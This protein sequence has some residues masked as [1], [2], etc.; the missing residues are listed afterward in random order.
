MYTKIIK[1]ETLKE[2]DELDCLDAFACSTPINTS[3]TSLTDLVI[4]VEIICCMKKLLESVYIPRVISILG[5]PN[6]WKPQLWIN[7]KK[8]KTVLT[9]HVYISKRIRMYLG[10]SGWSS[11]W[12]TQQKQFQGILF[13][14]KSETITDVYIMDYCDCDSLCEL[15]MRWKQRSDQSEEEGNKIS[16]SETLKQKGRSLMLK[17]KGSLGSQGIWSSMV[18]IIKQQKLN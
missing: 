1:N 17:T 6:N 18:Y 3:K 7:T 4:M 2:K 11:S 13:E 8:K 14:K 9:L 5:H 10:F 16:F 12:E 15:E